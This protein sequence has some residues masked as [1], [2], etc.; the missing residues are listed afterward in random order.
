MDSSS[1]DLDP[2]IHARVYVQTGRSNRSIL[3]IDILERNIIGQKNI[4][5]SP[6]SRLLT[7]DLSSS[8]KIQ[9]AINELNQF[10]N[11]MSTIDAKS[12]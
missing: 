4:L 9:L 8:N 1:P 6:L 2:Y 3:M 12:S 5:L 11:Q 7:A 10:I